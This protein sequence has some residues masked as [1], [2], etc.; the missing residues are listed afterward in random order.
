MLID[1][2]K[3]GEWIGLVPTSAEPMLVDERDKVPECV[4]A[5]L[6]VMQNFL[7]ESHGLPKPAP[8]ASTAEFQELLGK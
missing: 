1:Y 5:P 8:Y 6:G 4:V 7:G 3:N 2:I